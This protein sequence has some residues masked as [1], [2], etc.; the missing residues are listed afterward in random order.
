MQSA[1]ITNEKL[2][3]SQVVEI[4]DYLNLVAI[5]AIG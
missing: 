5:K 2:T 4:A 3:I 1:E